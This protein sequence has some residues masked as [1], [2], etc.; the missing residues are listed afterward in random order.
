MARGNGARELT[1]TR[2]TDRPRSHR[3]RI[4]TIAAATVLVLLAA[5]C[6]NASTNK[7]DN[8]GGSSSG[9][10]GTAAGGQV[11]VDATGVTPTAIRVGGVASVTNPLGGSY[12]DSFKGTQ[13]YF[14]M[15]NSQGGIYGR[16]LDLVAQVDDNAGNNQSAVQGLLTQDNVFAVLPVAV[17]LFTGANELVQ[18]NVPTFGWNINAEWG[19]TTAE[20]R[21]NMFGN[22]GSYLGITNPSPVLPW[23]AQDHHLHKLGV[24]AY[25]V[26]QSADC[27]TGIKNSFDKYGAAADAKV[28]FTDASLTFGTANMSVQVQ[29]MKAAGVD[30][31]A[32]CMDT[33]GVVTL[34]KEMKKQQ[35][36]AIQYLPDAYDS[37]FVANYG[38][39]F[40]G[41]IVRT[42]F[43]QF[44]LP[45]KPA[46]LQQ[47]LTWMA[48]TKGTLDEDSM[49]GWLAADQFYT[50]LKAA[51]PAFSRQKVI[52]ALNQMTDYKANGLLVGVNW[53]IEHT[54]NPPTFCQFLS[55]IKDS[56]Y[57]PDY[58]QPGKP[59]NCVVYKSGKLSAQY[60]S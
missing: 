11:P 14:N 3:G 28:V 49:N 20:P 54:G 9:P 21:S 59:F 30:M 44:E 38:D 53:K 8:G 36:N 42:D 13:A 60:T 26:A 16:K 6:G 37:K 41:S 50:G 55:T 18:A 46:G 47:Y 32:T 31:V 45:N 52:D 51:G 56:K 29:K 24:L 34:A 23:L 48:K 12:G 58:T 35:L 57:V 40:E 25:N 22:A 10:T 27:A 17:L 7:A 39:L 33:N 15:I 43:T 19:G 1:T 4:A 2:N 5:A